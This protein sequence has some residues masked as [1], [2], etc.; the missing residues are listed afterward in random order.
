M[1]F[2]SSHFKTEM[3]PVALFV[4]SETNS[5]INVSP[6]SISEENRFVRRSRRDLTDL[7]GCAI[8]EAI[9][10]QRSARRRAFTVPV[11]TCALKWIY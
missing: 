4:C 5:S 1:S 8:S 3:I 11:L 7:I 6:V 2:E 9:L 10:L